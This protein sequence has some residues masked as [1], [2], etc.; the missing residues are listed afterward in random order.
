[1][2]I[3]QRCQKRPAEI[4]TT[5]TI[6]GRQVY[7]ALCR[8]C[9]D[10][11]QKTASATSLID[12]FG[13]DLTQ[14]AKE[15]K[16]DPV[17]GRDEE[18]KRVVHILSR[19]TKNNP[20]LIGDPGVGKTAIVEGLAQKISA[21]Q[22]PE[23]LRGKRV[24]AL[25]M[26]SIIAGT[27]HRGQFEDR[28]KNILEEVVKAQGQ[29][30]I[31]MDELHT[32]VGAGAAEGAID[33]ANML[34]P[35]LARGE[36][37]LVGATTLDDYRR[38]IEKDAALERRFQ[39]VLVNEP[40]FSETIDIL[41]GLKTRYEKHHQ[42]FYSKEAIKAAV[43]FSDRYI[44]DRFLPDK[45]ID[46]LDEA[47]AEVRLSA[48]REPENLKQ[49]EREINDVKGEL[50]RDNVDKSKL[51]A[52][53]EEL[54]GVKKEL[55]E[56]WTKTKLEEIPAVKRE[57]IARIVSRATRIP[58]EE[59]TMEE[60]EKLLRLEDRIHT[61]IVN[62]E[63]AVKVVAEAIRRARAGLKDP[64]R[65]IGSFVFLGP[66]GVGK[67]ELTK[68]LAE[69]LYG[70]EDLMVRLDMSE[71]MEKHTVSR[72]IGSP[73]GYV[74]YD[75]A[76]QL[77]EIVRRKPFSIIL[78]DELEK[79]HSEVFN[80]LL[81][82][83]E[84]GRLTDAHGRTVD[85]KNTILV[86]TSNVGS[87]VINKTSQLGFSRSSKEEIAEETYETLKDKLMGVLKTTFKPEFLNRVDEVVVF[88]PLGK[89]E[90]RE[91][92][93]LQLVKTEKL[94]SEQGIVL[95][96]SSKARDYIAIEGY[97]PSFGARPIRRFIQGH[98]EN[99]ISEKVI[100]NEVL[101]GDTVLAD[102]KNNKLDVKVLSKVPV[103]AE[104]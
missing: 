88:K 17:I 94:L 27:S 99:K 25:D 1:M 72:M 3:C 21:G 92:V 85:F 76:G 87:D 39:P 23:T 28:L 83:M 93:D 57:D 6:E 62:Q 45:A 66:T 89:A 36:L 98:L 13:K 74:G 80:I 56:I 9:F 95:E 96:V 69:V 32:V 24:I 26:A 67:S 4:Q 18:I 14:L 44:S 19:R 82:I 102:I 8:V 35:S 91:I 61:R 103:K 52:K 10:E 38:R 53:L 16:L 42:V 51:T 15:D 63:E 22:V 20:V 46:L 64:K 12:K 2:I 41:N 31:F 90:I 65:P 86:M 101:A 71:Y 75:E 77:T 73:P 47:G 37:Q 60:R 78:F 43:E 50:A 81:Q 100:R 29:I 97:D 70:D 79:A 68:A 7:V 104:N 55:T 84:D 34:K 58:L 11:L 49:V 59:L 48:V 30:I 5:Q 33:A 40:T 54:N